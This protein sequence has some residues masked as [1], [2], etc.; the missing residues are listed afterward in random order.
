M[1]LGT[2][3]G[4]DAQKRAHLS[5]EVRGGEA[6]SRRPGQSTQAKGKPRTGVL[7]REHA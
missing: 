2:G 4:E 1:D 5:Q 6:V 7:K 3:P